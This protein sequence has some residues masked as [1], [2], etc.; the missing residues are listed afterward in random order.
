MKY[1]QFNPT[2]YESH[3]LV[4]G[5][6]ERGSEV[7]D[8]GCAAGYFAKKLK[9]KQCR[10][11]GIDSD[12]QS[13]Q[14][15]QKYCQK[16]I[17]ADLEQIKK[18][19]FRKKFDYILL[20]DILEHLE[21]PPSVL[22]L[23]KPCLESTGKVIVSVP[24]IAFLSVRLALLFGNFNYQKLGILDEN[25][26]HFYTKKTFQKLLKDSGF[27][28]E[29][30]EASSGFSQITKIGKYLNHIPKYWQYK[31]TR[32]RDTLLAYQFIAVCTLT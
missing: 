15:A 14:I 26:L 30:I 31:I 12:K 19:P 4:Y 22:N 17:V 10:V 3:M 8:I 6:I 23:I 1:S 5:R 20:L 13:A 18:L 7:L 9:E 27:K 25:H 2:P 32:L 28:I 11:W 21:N 29:E 24:N 16:V